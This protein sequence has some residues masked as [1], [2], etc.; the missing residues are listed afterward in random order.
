MS[1]GRVVGPI[2]K[3][4]TIDAPGLPPPSTVVVLPKP[5][6]A[7]RGALWMLFWTVG[8]LMGLFL[9]A[10]IG[11]DAL[12]S[13]ATTTRSVPGYVPA[14]SSNG[15]S[16]SA[17]GTM[18]AEIAAKLNPSPTT[19]PTPRPTA[20]GTV[21]ANY[22][23]ASQTTPGTYQMPPATSVPPTPYPMCRPDLKPGEWCEVMATEPTP[24]PTRAGAR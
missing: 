10:L 1:D 23:D 14:S 19:T 2:T 24:T 18:G 5:L 13:S 3:G 20:T 7:N 17:F 22:W 15:E 21:R 12:W 11:G 6:P 8:L 9:R 4:T 16:I